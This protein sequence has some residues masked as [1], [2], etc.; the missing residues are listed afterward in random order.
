VIT[1]AFVFIMW[2]ASGNNSLL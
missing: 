1:L 2:A